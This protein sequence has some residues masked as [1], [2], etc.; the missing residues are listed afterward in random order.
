MGAHRYV[1][2]LAISS[3][4]AVSVVRADRY[5]RLTDLCG[6]SVW[7]PGRRPHYEMETFHS[8]EDA[9]AWL[10]PLNERV[11]EEVSNDKNPGLAGRLTWIQARIGA[12]PFGRDHGRREACL[13]C[14]NAQF[15]KPR[16]SF[17]VSI[18]FP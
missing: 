8:S 15:S 2:R 11:W 5:A 17:G 10:D 6:F 4:A 3:L 16:A 14:G 12:G 1:R 13:V 18:N 9:Q 7:Y